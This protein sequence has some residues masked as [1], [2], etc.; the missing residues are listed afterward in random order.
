MSIGSRKTRRCADCGRPFLAL[1]RFKRCAPCERRHTRELA[2]SQQVREI[3]VM[4]ASNGV[5]VPL[6]PC[7]AEPPRLWAKIDAKLT[8]RHA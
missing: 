4:V 2:M 5:S 7:L 1:L 3:G 8:A 6:V